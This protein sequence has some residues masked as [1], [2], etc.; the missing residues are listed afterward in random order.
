MTRRK[1]WRPAIG[2]PQRAGRD[3]PRSQDLAGLSQTYLHGSSR[4]LPRTGPFNQDRWKDCVQPR[5][6][7]KPQRLLTLLV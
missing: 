7:V 4:R 5:D 2:G 3:R 6:K 1:P